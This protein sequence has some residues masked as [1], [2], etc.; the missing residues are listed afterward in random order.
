[1]S[2][3]NND[4]ILAK[5]F[6]VIKELADALSTKVEFLIDLELISSNGIKNV[7]QINNDNTEQI[8]IN[9]NI[10]VIENLVLSVED[11]V[12]LKILN[13]NPYNEIRDNFM[14][15]M[16][17]LIRSDAKQEYKNSSYHRGSNLIPKDKNM[18]RYI[19]ENKDNIKS[20]SLRSIKSDNHI[21]SIKSVE[22]DNILSYDTSIEIKRKSIVGKVD[23]DTEDYS[24]IE[25]IDER[26]EKVIKSIEKNEKFVL[27]NNA[28][29]VEVARPIEVESIDVLTDIHI[30]DCN[31]ITNQSP[32]Q[33]VK[34]IKEHKSEAI[35][36]AKSIYEKNIIGNIDT[37]LHLITPK[38]VDI[39]F[40]EPSNEN[41][42]KEE[43][44]DRYI[45]FDPTGENYIGVV[46]DD[47][48]FEP[49]KVSMKTITVL[50]DDVEN[51]LVNIDKDKNIVNHVIKDI[52]YSKSEFT[53]SL[54]VEYKDNL[55][56]YDKN[57]EILASNIISK[58]SK[59][60]NN[61]INKDET[62]SVVTKKDAELITG[63]K[64]IE[65]D[66]VSKID[67]IEKVDVIKNIKVEE[68][69]SN[70]IEDVK[71]NKQLAKV[72]NNIE[73]IKENVPIPFEEDINGSIELVGS[74]LLIVENNDL[75]ITIYPTSKINTII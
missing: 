27:T 23:V 42:N 52:N 62:V 57:N 46:L 59:E 51:I 4:R 63:I 48:T 71:L 49:L 40:I 15:E 58:S 33:A 24:V 75:G 72:I 53:D 16:E 55:L 54:E 50:P 67:N 37:N 25:S 2:K 5:V 11:I 29:E 32:A 26:K 43:V 68:I 12:K 13:I 66:L 36:D 70:V 20:I 22:K 56:Q 14:I 73:I 10:I 1:M 30:N 21:N 60:I 39:L 19:E 34:D 69:K 45:T 47:G 6:T 74:G 8:K 65:Y 9:K 28:K 44:K 7:I 38:K 61:I 18:D 3:K 64:N 35:V 31:L 41:I 17:N